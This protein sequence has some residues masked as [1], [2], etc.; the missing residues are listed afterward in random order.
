M[1]SLLIVPF[2]FAFLNVVAIKI[3]FTNLICQD[4][5]PDF[6]STQKCRL[7][8]VKR[9]VISLNVHVKLLQVPVNN[10]TVNLAAFKKANGFKPFLYNIT[11]DFCMFMANR[12]KFKFGE[13]FLNVL[14]KESNISHTCPY[15]HDIIVDNLVLNERKFAFLPL[16]R[17]EY[18]FQL[19]VAAYNVWNTLVKVY[20][21]ID[22]DL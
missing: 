12:K 11:G 1:K 17:G 19:R 20:I 14:L 15:D 10:I 7:V 8:V 2:A 21:S 9:G 6:S 22:G 3:R 18:M 4:L 16:P 5:R 13:V